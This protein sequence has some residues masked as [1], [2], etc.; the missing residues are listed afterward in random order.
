MQKVRRANFRD[1]LSIPAITDSKSDEGGSQTTDLCCVD[2][3]AFLIGFVHSGHERDH[4][5]LFLFDSQAKWIV[6]TYS[7]IVTIF[8]SGISRV[9]AAP[10]DCAPFSWSLVTMHLLPA[11]GT[12]FSKG[13]TAAG[14]VNHDHPSQALAFRHVAAALESTDVEMDVV[15]ELFRRYRP[16]MWGF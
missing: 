12:L 15:I 3:L 6:Q 11:G 2:L 14:L 5:C 16:C 1:V 10:N 13:M 8:R 7:G 4:A 9:Q